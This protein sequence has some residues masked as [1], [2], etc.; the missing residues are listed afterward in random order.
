MLPTLGENFGHAIF[1]SFAAGRPVLISD[2]TPWRGLAAKKAGW[3]IALEDE[4]AF[5]AAVQ[6]AA[7]M[8]QEE[9]N[10]WCDGARQLAEKVTKET[11]LKQHYLKLFN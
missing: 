4:K 7:G 3:D 2:K 10:E 9:F 8:G 5:I 11:D 1:E 6:Q